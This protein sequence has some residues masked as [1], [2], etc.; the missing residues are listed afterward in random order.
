MRIPALELTMQSKRVMATMSMMVRTP[1]PSGPTRHARAPRNSVSQEAL[2]TLPIF[3]LRRW[4]CIGFLPPSGRQR[5]SRKQVSPPGEAKSDVW[6]VVEFSKYFTT[7][8][9]WTEELLAQKP[10]LRGKTLYDVLFANGEVNKYGLDETAIDTC[11]LYLQ[12]GANPVDRTIATEEC[13]AMGRI[14]SCPRV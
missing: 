14:R 12:D 1:F 9:V 2:E 4:I 11:E 5:G 7:D 3:R 10:E 13:E 8:E 6:Q